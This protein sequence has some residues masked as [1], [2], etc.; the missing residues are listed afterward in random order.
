MK[1]ITLTLGIVLIAIIA[2]AQWNDNGSNLTTTDNVGIGTTSA[3]SPLHIQSSTNRTIRLDFTG[4][5]AGESYTW[6]SWQANSVEQWRIV[7]RDN[8]NAK[9]EIWNKNSDDVL[10]LLQNGNVGIGTNNPSGQWGEKLHVY[11]NNANT[12][13]R[14]R[15][16]DGASASFLA[17]QDAVYLG[18]GSNHKLGLLINGSTKLLINEQGNV[19][20]GT[21]ST[22]SHK[23]AVEGSI[24]AREIKVEA[25]GWSDFVFK[26]DYKLRPL[27]EIE[28]YIIKNKHLPGIPS[29]KQVTENGINLGEMNAKLLQKIEELTLY[30]I[31]QNK[32]NHAQQ[33][34][35]EKLQKEVSALKNE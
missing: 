5:G 4:I 26:D 7:G 9:L 21:S 8:D 33:K 35:I 10:S 29:E 2:K 16:I 25:S 13:I 17:Y 14:I 31:E 1:K 28:N 34:L 11:S 18:S 23:L 30:L 12:G 6:Q 24:G 32:E 19:G 3:L 20:I 15:R 22:G 27:E